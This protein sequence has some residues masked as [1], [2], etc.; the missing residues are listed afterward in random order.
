[1]INRRWLDLVKLEAERNAWKM[2]ED[3]EIMYEGEEDEE[4]PQPEQE[5]I[6]SSLEIP[7]SPLE[8]DM[9]S[10]PVSLPGRTGMLQSQ[11]P[12]LL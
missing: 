10:A 8:D 5:L 2:W 6:P 3:F 4:W 7:G 11:A 12:E 9:E 1:M